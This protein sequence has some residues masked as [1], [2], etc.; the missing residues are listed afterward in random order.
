MIRKELEGTL[1]LFARQY[2]QDHFD[3]ETNKAVQLATY[4]LYYGHS[5]SDAAEPPADEYGNEN[6]W[7]G[8]SFERACDTIKSA[9]EEVPSVLYVDIQC[10]D[11]TTSEPEPLKCERC[12]G[13]G[14]VVDEDE[15]L[16]VYDCDDCGGL[17]YFDDSGDW[18]QVNHKELVAAIVGKELANYL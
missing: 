6:E 17:G 4:D 16:L 8:Y 18:Y 12:D 5:L 7:S 10:D 9:L 14:E 11:W 3:A 2:R 1:K 13:E 15:E